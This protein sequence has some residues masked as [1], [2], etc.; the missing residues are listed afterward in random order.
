MPYNKNS[1]WLFIHI[2]KT[3]GGSITQSLQQESSHKSSKPR[4]NTLKMGSLLLLRK[5]IQFVGQGD[6]SGLHGAYPYTLSLE[7]LTYR[8]IELLQLLPPDTLRSAFKFAVVRNP[9]QRAVSSFYSHNRNTRYKDFEAFCFDWFEAYES[10]A[11][12]EQA[13]RLP[14]YDFIIDL[15][16]NNAMDFILRYESLKADFN[17]LQ[18]K[19]G[20]PESPLPH[21]HRKA[22]NKATDYREHYTATTKKKIAQL[23]ERDI[24]YFGYTF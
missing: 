21:V 19:L 10:D 18:N 2:P 3:A 1:K 7:H 4:E 16:G 8:A 9:W 22:G 11:H 5:S 23:F 14:Q 6:L 15:D 17:E 13:H 20:F 12:D 24:D